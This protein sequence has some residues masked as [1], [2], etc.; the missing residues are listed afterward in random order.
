MNN[1][2][3][4]DRLLLRKMSSEEWNNYIA[5]IIEADEFYYQYGLGTSKELIESLKE[6]VSVVDY[7]SIILRD[8]EEMA[9]YIG[10]CTEYE[11]IE[12][13][14]FKEFRRKHFCSEALSAFLNAYLGG[15]LTGEQHDHTCAETLLENEPAAKALIKAGFRITGINLEGAVIFEYGKGENNEVSDVRSINL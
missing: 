1:E 12:F 5:H 7:Y 15:E 10:A 14:V 13:Y 6:P 11:N 8:T 4:T 3:K 2:L 9:G